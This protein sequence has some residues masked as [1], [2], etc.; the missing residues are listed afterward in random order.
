[1]TSELSTKNGSPDPSSRTWRASARGPAVPMGSS[2]REMVICARK[3]TPD[4]AHYNARKRHTA[5]RCTEVAMAAAPVPRA[6]HP[7]TIC[8]PHLGGFIPQCKLGRGSGWT[9]EQ[10]ERLPRVLRRVQMV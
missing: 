4:R 7:R 6:R 1:M 5:Q 8:A 10:P 3:E 2:S 9:R